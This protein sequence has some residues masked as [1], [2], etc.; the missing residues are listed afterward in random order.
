MKM[1][2]N[3]NQL[4]VGYKI[5]LDLAYPLPFLLSSNAC[6]EMTK[7]QFHNIREISYIQKQQVIKK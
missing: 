6:F 2:Y 7:T 3:K 5:Q 4:E 1:D